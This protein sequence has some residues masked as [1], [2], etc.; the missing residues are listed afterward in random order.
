MQSTLSKTNYKKST[1]TEFIESGIEL[2]LDPQGKQH[3]KLHVNRSEAVA[4]SHVNKLTVDAGGVK[5][6]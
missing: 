5:M 2:K 1:N 6:T 4:Q 3:L